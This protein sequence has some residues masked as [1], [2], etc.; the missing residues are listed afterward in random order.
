MRGYV[1]LNKPEIKIVIQ[2]ILAN[3][4]KVMI[5]LKEIKIS[6][7]EDMTYLNGVKF[8]RYDRHHH[9]PDVKYWPIAIYLYLQA[10]D[11]VSKNTKVGM[12]I[13]KIPDCWKL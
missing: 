2:D 7:E 4:W 5:P 12:F 11:D 6:V 13:K 10:I 1:N 8:F 9:Y 3:N